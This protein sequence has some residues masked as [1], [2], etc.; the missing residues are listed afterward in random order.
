[1]LDG[2]RGTEPISRSSKIIFNS[3][4]KEKIIS[5]LEKTAKFAFLLLS[6]QKYS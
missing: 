6:Q 1:M 4:G 2:P 5:P 3:N